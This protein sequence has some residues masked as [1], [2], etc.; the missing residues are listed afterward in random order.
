MAI[1]FPW[2]SISVSRVAAS[3]TNPDGGGTENGST[4]QRT[5]KAAKCQGY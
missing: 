3:D 4:Q 5:R 2:L 1:P